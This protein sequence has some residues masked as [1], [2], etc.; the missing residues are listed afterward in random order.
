MAEQYDP[1]ALRE[2]IQQV[3]AA[4]EASCKSLL[5]VAA[6]TGAPPAEIARLCDEMDIH[7]RTCQLGCFR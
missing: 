1:D 4:G 5:A 3:A 7:I 2:K 6:D